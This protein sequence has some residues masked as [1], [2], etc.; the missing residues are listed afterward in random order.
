MGKFTGVLLVSDFDG[1]V[2]GSFTGMPQSNID[3]A[4]E[5]IKEG[6]IFTIATGRTYATFSPQWDIIPTNAPTILSNG[7]SVYDFHSDTSLEMRYLPTTAQEDLIKLSETMPQLAMEVYHKSDIY[8]HH[9]NPVTDQHMEIVG[10]HYIPCHLKD[11]P[12]PWLKVLIQEEHDVLET[13]RQC[14]Q[15][16]RPN[17]YETIFSNPRYLEVTDLGVTKGC[18]VLNLAKK[19]NISPENIYCMGDNENDIP[20]LEISALPMAP[21]TSAQVV[22]DQKPHLLSSCKE[23]ALASAV[24]LLHTRYS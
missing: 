21:S 2:F 16:L 9:P 7:A 24:A 1:T 17:T 12:S 10:G 18:A 20:M 23:G 4:K 8:A 13:A 19:Y 11:V 22:L 3:A 5:F 6:G 15:Q 14:L